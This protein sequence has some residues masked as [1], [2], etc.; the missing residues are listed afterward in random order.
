MCVKS[1]VMLVHISHIT[2]LYVFLGTFSIL[3]QVTMMIKTVGL[4]RNQEDSHIHLLTVTTVYL[5]MSL[6]SGGVVFRE[7]V[8]FTPGQWL[9]LSLTSLDCI[10]LLGGYIFVKTFW[11]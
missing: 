8:N 9:Q 3:I 7:C 11:K 5:I 2:I 10:I 1:A 6:I 4:Y